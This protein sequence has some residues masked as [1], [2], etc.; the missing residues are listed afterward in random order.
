MKS[1]KAL[2]ANEQ[3]ASAFRS[4]EDMSF[5]SAAISC[6]NV[7]VLIRLMCHTLWRPEISLIFTTHLLGV[8][9]KANTFNSCEGYMWVTS[10]SCFLKLNFYSHTFLIKCFIAFCYK[11]G[12]TTGSNVATWVKNSLNLTM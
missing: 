6:N 11:F 4:L 12:N 9:A 2:C 3:Q 10:K 1:W 8:L 5:Q 7:S